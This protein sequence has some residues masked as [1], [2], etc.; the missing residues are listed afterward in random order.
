MGPT[1][2]SY[3]AGLG[4]QKNSHN[5]GRLSG[6]AAFWKYKPPGPCLS[7]HGWTDPLSCVPQRQPVRDALRILRISR[8]TALAKPPRMFE[9]LH[10][11]RVESLAT[12]SC[13]RLLRDKSREVLAQVRQ[14]FPAEMGR[15]N[16]RGAL[17][18]MIRAVPLSESL[19]RSTTA[20]LILR[21]FS[22]NAKCRK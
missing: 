18:L 17:C 22:R 3:L 4:P 20:M 8:A 14:P 13:S 7:P 16:V 9:Q 15:A 10:S 5:S 1:Y 19:I 6:N 12:A 21:G 11:Q 2:G